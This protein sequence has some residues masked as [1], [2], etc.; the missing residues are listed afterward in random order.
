[1][2]S[3]LIL[4]L[5]R[6][7]V[8]KKDITDKISVP[9]TLKIIQDDWFDSPCSSCYG[10][11]CCS[12]LPLTTMKLEN[13]TD[14][15]NLALLSCYDKIRLGLKKSGEWVVY[16]HQSCRF[17]H[18]EAFQCTIHGLDTQSLVCKTYNAYTCW[19]KPAFITNQ[20]KKII[21]FN[22]SRLCALEKRADLFKRGYLAAD[23]DWDT[24]VYEMSLIP[25]QETPAGRI[26]SG[27][28]IRKILPFTMNSSHRFLFF[29][30]Y[31]KAQRKVHFD[32]LT[33]RLGFPG[34]FLALTDNSWAFMVCTQLRKP[35][36]RYLTREYSPS[37][38]AD[39]GCFSF[40]QLNK[41]RFFY[42]EI[43]NKWI[44]LRLGEIALLKTFT[45]YDSAG[46]I[47]KLPSTGELLSLLGSRFPYKPDRAA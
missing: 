16:Y 41:E 28:L 3:L 4:P 35:L 43:G 18:P 26:V 21:F 10:S 13:R 25:L 36:F 11:P 33:F 46:N 6:F 17:L 39:S 42:S 8:T 15:L 29:P 31:N 34:V 14:F 2:C 5:M 23:L 22:L 47:T 20:N 32:L 9:R 40:H 37:F 30:P 45:E 7:N 27:K 12:H 38:Q 1:M 44:I 24:L 19:Y